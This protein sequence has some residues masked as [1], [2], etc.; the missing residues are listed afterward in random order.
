MKRREKSFLGAF[1]LS[2]GLMLMQYIPLEWRPLGM[3]IFTVVTYLVTAWVLFDN[4]DGVEWMT[5]VPMP[6]LYT[7][8]I[9][10]FYFL[11]PESVIAQAIIVSIFGLGMYAL[12]LAG[13]ILTI[14]KTRTIQLLRAAQAVIF[15]FSLIAALLAF[16]TLF[17]LGWLFIWNA[18]IAWG[19]GILLSFCFYW[20]IRLGKNI[21]RE[22]FG[23]TLRTGTLLGFL[24]G[25]VSFFPGN[26]WPTSL[27][28]MGAMYTMLG[29]GQSALEE[30]LFTN[31]VRE[32][33][34]VFVGVVIMFFVLLPWK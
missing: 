10:S 3:V 2:L 34:G 4:L 17:S 7:A 28:L 22:V 24:A 30:K 13:N 15:F 14:A 23:L 5:I 16:N 32:Y 11:L 26:L 21:S 18:L 20:S 8:S 6:A 31:T 33:L 27:L 12:L 25:I 1:I 19:I 29:V 9:S